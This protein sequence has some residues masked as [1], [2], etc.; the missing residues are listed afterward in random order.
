MAIGIVAPN[1]N[2][3]IGWID[4]IQPL[5]LQRTSC[6]MV[7]DFHHIHPFRLFVLAHPRQGFLFNIGGKEHLV[8]A[9]GQPGHDRAIVEP[10][11][12]ETARRRRPCIG[13]ENGFNTFKEQSPSMTVSRPARTTC[14]V[15]PCCA[16]ASVSR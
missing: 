5:G 13:G 11:P 10:M 6:A 9:A 12:L 2:D 8:G 7:R 4:P 15:K 14:S 16:S 1:R 3:G